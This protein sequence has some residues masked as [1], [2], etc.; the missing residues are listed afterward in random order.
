MMLSFSLS[1]SVCVQEDNERFSIVAHTYSEMHKK[2][3]VE[4]VRHMVSK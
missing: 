2:Q 4:F 1:L 3:T